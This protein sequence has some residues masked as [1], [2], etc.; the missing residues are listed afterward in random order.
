[1]D[2]FIANQLRDD[3]IEVNGEDLTCISVRLYSLGTLM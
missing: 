2:Y 3:L 1:M